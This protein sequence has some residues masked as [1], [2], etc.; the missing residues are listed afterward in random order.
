MEAR[1]ARMMGGDV[2]VSIEPGKGYC[3]PFCS[4]GFELQRL[5]SAFTSW[6][7]RIGLEPRSRQLASL[8]TGTHAGNRWPQLLITL[9]HGTWAVGSFRD[10]KVAEGNDAD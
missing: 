10:A 2:I 3:Q 6:R 4:F 8:K 7:A 9:V 1:L 5:C